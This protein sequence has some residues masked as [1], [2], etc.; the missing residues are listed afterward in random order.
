MSSTK[1]H[2][3]EVIINT[4]KQMSAE[5]QQTALKINELSQEKDSHRLV[6]E[7]LS[8]LEPERKAF[9]LIGGVLVQ[10]TVGEILP[11][12]QTN[13]EGIKELIS[14]LEANLATK[15]KDRNDYKILHGIMSQDEREQRMKSEQRMMSA[16]K[17]N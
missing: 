16:V 11:I 8:K 10:R 13:Y 5:C 14:K 1:D 17:S 3:P 12:V 2:D 9:R 15:D 6:I 7:N 4:Y